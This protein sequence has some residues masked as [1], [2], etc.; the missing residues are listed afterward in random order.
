MS[1]EKEQ[2]ELRTNITKK[3]IKM[4][5][6]GRRGQICTVQWSKAAH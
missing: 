3:N 1:S 4:K 6:T 2:I 5:E